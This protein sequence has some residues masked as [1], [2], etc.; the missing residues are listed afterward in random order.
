MLLNEADGYCRRYPPTLKVDG[1]SG[2][3]PPVRPDWICGEWAEAPQVIERPPEPISEADF[4][5]D[6]ELARTELDVRSANCLRNGGYWTVDEVQRATD[7]E[8]LRINNLGRKS[9]KNIRDV[10]G[11]AKT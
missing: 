2:T 11:Q 3:F 8:L 10:L 4:Y 7:A 5:R 9:L 1:V 6:S